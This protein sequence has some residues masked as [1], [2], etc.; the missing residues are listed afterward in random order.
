MDH[1]RRGGH[2]A[3]EH[4]E[5]YKICLAL[6]EKDVIPDFREPNVIRIAPVALY[7]SFEDVY[8]LADI[9]EEIGETKSYEKFSDK[10]ALVV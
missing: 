1:N 4:E 9:L 8:R 10:R 6:K 3:L 7:V 5:A 2:V